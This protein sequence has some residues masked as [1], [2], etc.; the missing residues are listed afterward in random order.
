[1]VKKAKKASVLI[2]LIFLGGC[3]S[4][5][6]ENVLKEVREDITLQMVQGLP[7]RYAGEKVV[8]GGMIVTVENLEDSTVIEVFQ[9]RL[10]STHTPT[11]ALT[12][13]GGR[14]LVKVSGYLDV[15]V[16][17]PNKMLT[18]AGVVKGVE[19][20]KIGKTDYPYPVVTALEMRLFEPR[21]EPEYPNPPP[22]WSFPPYEPYWPYYWPYY[23]WWAPFPP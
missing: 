1:M 8:W 13:E 22:W 17:R 7:E 3:A 6:S 16:Y 2:A 14:F 5:I 19:I 20:K 4:V 12:G 23:P 15:F 10:D 18:V 21:A 9:T 11:N